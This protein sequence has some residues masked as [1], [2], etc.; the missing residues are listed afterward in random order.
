MKKF[1]L[2]LG[3]GLAGCGGAQHELQYAT[4][5][6]VCLAAEHQIVVR[7]GTTEADDLAAMAQLRSV[8]N[9]LL[10]RAEGDT[11]CPF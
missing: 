7:Q 2:I 3:L 5:E 8:C 1:A 4:V 10:C 6:G 11:E 9:V